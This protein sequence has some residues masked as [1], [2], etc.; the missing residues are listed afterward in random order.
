MEK[1]YYCSH[2]WII[3]PNTGRK[4]MGVCKLC[5]E[6][7]IFSNNYHMMWLKGKEITNAH[8]RSNKRPNSQIYSNPTK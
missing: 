8:K 3:E 7:Q 5:E 2:Y 4:S 6:T 1:G